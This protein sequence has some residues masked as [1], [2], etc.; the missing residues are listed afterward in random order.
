MDRS[1]FC[2]PFPC[3]GNVTASQV[4][5]REV[6]GE[7]LIACARL[8]QVAAGFNDRDAVP[9]WEMQ[10]SVLHGGLAL[11]AFVGQE[12]VGFLYASSACDGAQPYL[13]TTSLSVKQAFESRG[14]GT[15]LKTALRSRAL[16]L[17]HDRIRWNVSP[18]AS[19]AL[20]VY[21]SKLGAALVGYC[22]GMYRSLGVDPTEDQAEIEW[23][24]RGRTHDA[25]EPLTGG[26]TV[27][28]PWAFDAK[29][30]THDELD[31]WRTQVRSA[32]QSCLRE[33]LVG[34][35]VGLDHAARRSFVAFA[36]G[37]PTARDR[38]VNPFTPAWGQSAAR[39]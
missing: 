12:L 24:L 31:R 1:V 33:G 25:D 11:G 14:I 26:R 16:E 13:Y 18:L 30:C 9:P 35:S 29:R 21:L 39:A 17:G 37:G 22:S 38:K 3:V 34:V 5:I 4:F 15:A 6:A 27:E 36:P 8:L 10:A 2:T 7:D 23:L 20:Y 32:M 19:R 28:I